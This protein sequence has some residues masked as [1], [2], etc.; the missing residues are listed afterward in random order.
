MKLLA[1]LGIAALALLGCSQGAAPTKQEYVGVADGVCKAAD[2]ALTELYDAHRK[3]NPD[4]GANQRFIRTKVI[5]R[6]RQMT[7]ELRSIQPPENDGQYLA[8]IYGSYEHAIDLLYTD[9]LGDRSDTAGEAAEARMDVYGMHAC[10]KVGEE[11]T[12]RTEG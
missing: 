4:G 7:Q 12:G 10:G 9:P 1:A 5:P 2:G 11:A 3:T 8:D 6:L